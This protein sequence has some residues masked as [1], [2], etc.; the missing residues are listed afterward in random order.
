MR[1]SY[2]WLKEL[3]GFKETPQKLAE[4]LT[5]R[6]FEVETI[7]KSGK[8]WAIDIA[9]KTIGP[10]MADVSGH[11]G[12][13]REIA[14]SLGKRFR[15]PAD[16][17][18]ISV[19]REKRLRV[20]PGLDP[21]I[22]VQYPELCSRYTAQLI[23][24]VGMEA[25]P[26]WMQERL[27][28]CGLRPIN[29]IV[30]V[31]NYV[32]LEMGHPLHAFDADKITGNTMTIRASKKAESI[33]TLDGVRRDLPEGA[34]IIEDDDGIIDLA[35]IMGGE[36]SAV[37]EETKTILLQAAVFDQARIYRVSHEMKHATAA[38]KIY[39]AG[40]DETGSLAALER[41]VSLLED[42]ADASRVGS[43]F[44]W[45]PR[46]SKPRP[47]GFRPSYADRMIGQS[48]GAA[49]YK[50]VFERLGLAVKQRKENL[51]VEIP[52][53]RKDISIEEDLVEEAVR[54][55]G[56]ENIQPRFP[57]LALVPAPR[58]DDMFWEDR[59]RDYAS[60]AGFSE[61]ECYEFASDAELVA[62]GLDARHAVELQNPLNQETKY[63]VP[64]ALITYISVTRDNLKYADD[65]RLFG[66]AKNFR[67][68]NGK[69]GTAVEEVKKICLASVF[70]DATGDEGFYRLKGIVDRIFESMGLDDWQYDDMPSG[71]AVMSDAAIFHPYRRAEIRVN[72]VYVGVLG[73]VNPAVL[74]A[75]KTK[76]RIVACEIDA[77]TLY[78]LANAEVEFRPIG[79]FPSIERDIAVIVPS[80]LK[81]EAVQNIIENQ[82]GGFLADTDLF[83]YFQ[84]EDMR[85][86]D[87]KSLAFHLVFQSPDRT[88]TDEEVE[89]KMQRITKALKDQG[90]EV[91]K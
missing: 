44:D 69:N 39:A 47:I 19:R 18:K 11:I 54:L 8:D 22:T 57:E 1:F 3:V 49:F 5:L 75:L 85:D 55:F 2:K 7:E 21:K 71:G 65:V 43:P 50:S 17:I 27:V 59:V 88:L 15:P 68:V 4:L 9:G 70:K 82:G 61:H 45:Y 41:A 25:S 14:A 79:K 16:K 52:P 34:I 40:V 24:V 26:K 36:D 20:S 84:D 10:R 33:V 6:S 23:A 30:D 48:L 83:D 35:G 77:Q 42:V 86:A 13:A 28:T 63:L 51:I 53:R 67:R 60:G 66:I 12:M 62:F 76:T 73:E 29:V 56:Y 58:N 80:N 78:K 32:M 31:T 64:R 46:E 89:A 90:W 74:D 72:D 37:S 87:Q 91:R 38:S 81:T